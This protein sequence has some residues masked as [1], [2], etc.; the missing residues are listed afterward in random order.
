MLAHARQTLR[1][2]RQAQEGNRD[3]LGSLLANTGSGLGSAADSLYTAA[4][5]PDSANLTQ[6]LNSMAERASQLSAEVHELEANLLNHPAM[7]ALTTVEPKRSIKGS[8]F[9]L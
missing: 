3:E 5:L 4:D 7:P 2:P 8:A 9:P 6:Y 1:T